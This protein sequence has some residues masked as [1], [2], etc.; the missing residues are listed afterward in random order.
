MLNMMPDVVQICLDQEKLIN[1][2]RHAPELLTGATI[3]M[4]Q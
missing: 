3:A 1:F 2:V 4:R